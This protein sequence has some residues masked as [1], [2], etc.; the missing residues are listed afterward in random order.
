[1]VLLMAYVTA[2]VKFIFDHIFFE[3]IW[4]LVTTLAANVKRSIT[5]VFI[6]YEYLIWWP[7]LAAEFMVV[8]IFPLTLVC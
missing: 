6:S 7:E 8:F 5:T 1:M 3:H 4:L 2:K